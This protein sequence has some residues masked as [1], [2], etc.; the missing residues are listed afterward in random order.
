M[1]RLILIALTASTGLVCL[2]DASKSSAANSDEFFEKRIRPILANNCFNCHSALTNSKGGLR[3]DDRQGLLTGGQSGSAVVPGKP[4]ESLL[5]SAVSYAHDELK[6]P[7]TKRLSVE[8]VSDLREWI[9]AGAHWPAARL[10]KGFGSL[11]EHMQSLKKSH[12]AWQP[13]KRVAVPD[14]RDPAWARSDVDRFALRKWEELGWEPLPDASAAKRIRRLHFDLTGLPPTS[15]EVESF[16]AD[17]SPRAWIER[18]DRLLESKAFGEKWG[19]HWL[20]V[21]RYAEST[22]PSRNIPYPHA[23]RYRDYVINAF[24]ADKPFNVF[25]REQIAGDLL[26]AETEQ[27][28]LEKTVATG[29]LAIGMKD[30]NQRFKVRFLMDNVDEQI[31]TVSR[32]LLAL[33]VSCAR[34]H[35]HKYDPIT[36]REYYGLAGIFTSTELC[37]GVRSKMGG[38]GLD[39]YAPESLIVL[40]AGGGPKPDPAQVEELRQKTEQAKIAFQELRGKPEGNV[41]NAEGVPK[42]GAARQRWLQLQQELVALT[43]PASHGVAIMGVRDAARPADTQIRV[44]GEAEKL[45]PTAPRGFLELVPS[46]SSNS[47]EPSHSGRLELAEWITSP[48]NPLTARVIV[49]RVWKHLF[50]EGLVRTVD[51]FGATGDTPSHPE[52]LDYLA[53]QFVQDGWSIKRLVRRLA[54]TRVYQLDSKSS[55]AQVAAD[56]DNRLLWRHAPRRLSAEELRDS[57]LFIAGNLD[58]QPADKSEAATLKIVEINNN[59]PEAKRLAKVALESRR[60]SIYLPL[61]RDLVPLSLSVFDF[62]DQSFVVGR[63]DVTNVPSQSLF[64]LNSKFVLRESLSVAQK[65]ITREADDTERVKA[66]YRWIFGREAT[67]PEVSAGLGFLQDLL[68]I[69]RAFPQE[70]VANASLVVPSPPSGEARTKLPR[71]KPARENRIA[72]KDSA[73][74]ASKKV[75]AKV[76]NA[77]I[78]ANPSEAVK[79]EPFSLPSD[80]KTLA[81]MMLCQ[82]LYASAEFR[83]LQ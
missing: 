20:D 10:P 55:P 82:S 3:V 57:I 31:D 26:P 17:S 77:Q 4:D 76:S 58:G 69:V 25:I 75:A 59:G 19:R 60:R 80:A 42:R 33:T 1:R 16:V 21:A 39:Y 79:D 67:P 6:M 18:V 72:S 38:A 23:W 44:R 47:I 64:F 8:E 22:G 12:W 52:L 65:L 2:A 81:W 43:D 11:D 41:L 27:D 73:D 62:A 35:D 32:S 70:S 53:E 30:V 48:T 15:A 74:R 68:R 36:S 29:F 14:V 78:D 37:A 49:N 46:S 54:L 13:R 66:A 56:P 24:N 34:C 45:G 63:R 40:G 28:R 83:Y 5:I 9:A 71:S 50:N 7:P 51:N 61:L